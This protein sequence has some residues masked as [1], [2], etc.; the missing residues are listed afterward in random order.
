MKPVRGGNYAA[1]ALAYTGDGE[2]VEET[3]M[4]FDTAGNVGI[5]TT[6]P[7]AELHVAG[8]GAIV[9]P[10]GTTAQQPT[11][12]TGMIRFNTDYRKVRIL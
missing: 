8:T 6:S 3:N 1:S 7:D 4:H 9:V 10:S 11:G 2:I 12:V 5:G